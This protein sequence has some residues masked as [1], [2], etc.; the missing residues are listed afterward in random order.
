MFLLLSSHLLK[1]HDLSQLLQLELESLLLSLPCSWITVS[2]PVYLY[3]LCLPTCTLW[4]LYPDMAHLSDY[5]SR[6]KGRL[7]RQMQ[8]WE[9]ILSLRVVSHLYLKCSFGQKVM[10]QLFFLPKVCAGVFYH[11]GPFYRACF[12]FV[13]WRASLHLLCLWCCSAQFWL[14]LAYCRYTWPTFG[15]GSQL[16]VTS[17]YELY[18]WF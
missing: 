13:K 1:T 16:Q 3:P 7:V 15:K 9:R 17:I 10:T 4:A 18:F 8:K 2:W 5:L 11:F 12:T 14:R 6:S